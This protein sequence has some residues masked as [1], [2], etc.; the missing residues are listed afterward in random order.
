MSDGN[1]AR[2]IDIDQGNGD[3]NLEF[4]DW[5]PDSYREEFGDWNLE[6][7]DWNSILCFLL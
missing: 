5:S 7:G 4:G 1:A 3:W 2:F 6:E